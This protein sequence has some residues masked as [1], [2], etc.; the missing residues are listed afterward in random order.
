MKANSHI[1]KNQEISI[2]SLKGFCEQA[3]CS[4]PEEAFK[5]LLSYLLLLLQWNKKMNLVGASTWQTL[6]TDLIMDSFY[7]AQFLDTLSIA[8]N[9]EICDLGSGAGLP[10]IP[11]RMIWHRGNY[12]LVEVREKRALFLSFVLSRLELPRTS[13]FRGRAEDFLMQKQSVDLVISRA[14]LPWKKVLQ[15]VEG[16]LPTGAVTIFL[17]HTPAPTPTEIPSGWKNLSEYA[18]PSGKQIRYFWALSRS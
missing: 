13:V 4:V 1:S 15:Y 16:H 2:E 18:Y 5:P 9:A 17:T 14:F 11:L 3:S 8:D 10:G 7:L 6:F 12:S